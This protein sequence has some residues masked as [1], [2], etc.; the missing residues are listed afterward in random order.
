MVRLRIALMIFV[1]PTPGRS[2]TWSAEFWITEAS[3]LTDLLIFVDCEN[4]DNDLNRVAVVSIVRP[5]FV[6]TC[7]A[8]RMDTEKSLSEPTVVAKPS[9]QHVHPPAAFQ[10]SLVR[11]QLGHVPQCPSI[12]QNKS[13]LAQWS[14]YFTY[15]FNDIGLWQSAFIEFVGTA[16]MSYI[17][18]LIDV[19][20]GNFDTSQV[21]AYVGVSNIV[22][23]SIFIMAAAPASG[24]HLNPLITYSTVLTGLSGFAR[25]NQPWP[26]GLP[27]TTSIHAKPRPGLL[28]IAAQTMGAALTG[29]ILRGV[30]GPERAVEWQGGG[31]WRDPGT[32]N[33]GQALLIETVSSFILLFLAYGVAL[34]PRQGKLFGPITG[35][36]SVGLSLGL[37]SFASA[38]LVK[39]Y[40]GASM[41]PARCFAF[42]ITRK[43]FSS[44]WI[45]WTGPVIG[46]ILHAVTYYVCPP[47]HQHVTSKCRMPPS[48]HT[49]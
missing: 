6:H 5:L 25:G 11:N 35:P 44:Q 22:L 14:R 42:A 28:Y 43:E 39:G 48:S 27:L 10:G 24:G 13:D 47:Y 46:G 36:I 4:S 2:G 21:P 41:N 30:F 34:D 33:V 31:C 15:G 7:C 40:T 8:L 17:S 38:G 19:T 9:E 26:F 16:A 37:T 29:G 1:L 20:V 32:V 49:S 18:G 12:P 45:W 23:L 3:N